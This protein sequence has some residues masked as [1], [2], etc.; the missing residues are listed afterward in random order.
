MVEVVNAGCGQEGPGPFQQR[1]VQV[2]PVHVLESGAKVLG[3]ELN[4]YENLPRMLENVVAI[5]H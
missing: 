3:G 4:V 1:N 2:V 5:N